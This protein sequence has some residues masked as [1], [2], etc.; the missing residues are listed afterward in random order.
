MPPFKPVYQVKPDLRPTKVGYGS[1][2]VTRDISSE[3][4]TTL[5]NYKKSIAHRD[6]KPV[7]Q[8]KPDLRPSK[9]NTGSIVSP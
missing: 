9:W 1:N 2:G 3:D 8:V 5:S 4:I 7:Y 6:H